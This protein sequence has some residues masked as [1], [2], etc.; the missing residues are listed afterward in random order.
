M[1]DGNELGRR[2]KVPRTPDALDVALDGASDDVASHL[3][4]KHSRLIDAQIRSERLDHGAKRTLIALRFAIGLVGLIIAVGLVWVLLTARSD[5]GLVIEAFSVPPDLAQRGLTGETLAGNLSDRIADIDRQATSFRSPETLQTN[6]GNDIRIE[7]PS[8]GISIDEL[9]RY[10][11]RTLGSQ[12]IIGGAVFREP[13]GLRLTVRTGSLGTIEQTGSDANLEAMVQKAAE[14]V[15]RRTQAYRYS[16]YLEFNGRRDE[17]MAVARDLAA[18]SDDPRER[19]WAWAQI[20]NLLEMADMRASAAAGYR[21]IQEDP[22]NALAYLN[23]CI[24][25]DHLSYAGASRS[26]CRKAA[27]LG[28]RP[29]GGL[30]SIGVNTSLANLATGPSEQGDFEA[31][32]RQLQTIHGR[33]Y[34]GVRELN[35]AAISTLLTAMHDVT[36]SR[37]VGGVPSEAYLAAH[38]ANSSGLATPQVDQAVA[39]D[40][41]SRAIVLLRQMLA[42]V[43]RQPEGADLAQLERERTILPRL[44]IYTAM[45]G[46]VRDAQRMVTSLPNDCFNCIVA[47]AAVA[48][49]GGDFATARRLIETA[50][51]T[52]PTSPFTDE[53]YAELLFR[54]GRYKEAL[55]FATR[56]TANGPR[57]ADAL[58]VRGDALRKLGRVKEADDFYAKAEVA[59][60][61]WGR[62]QID[63]AVADYRLGKTNQAHD[64][65]RK[66][67]TLDL[68]AKDRIVLS[69]L[70][71]TIH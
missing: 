4:E 6:W 10:L 19:A 8:T 34:N 43:D 52:L 1:A 38:F 50:D 26:V 64:R 20:S 67:S 57:F 9:D 59:A 41:W 7:I 40:D 24:A 54:A 39:L 21:A 16:K 44:A 61:R 55:E 18:T 3:L 71:A 47:K 31:T 17:A 46:Q 30:S 36:G 70:Q 68:S 25:L 2:R 22:T 53:G 33:E 60:P 37:R 62:L 66:A 28:S 69:R 65:L 14:G 45:N 13:A 15:F 49:L 23:T 51:A 5:H 11:H 12:T 56:A 29:E 27:Q 32:L 58:K 48:G 42:V 35:R 63:R